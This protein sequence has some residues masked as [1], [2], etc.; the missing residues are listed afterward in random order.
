MSK[1]TVTAVAASLALAAATSILA[2]A[3]A[4][5]R[6]TAPGDRAD[7]VPVAPCALPVVKLKKKRQVAVPVVGRC[8]VPADAVAVA[9]DLQ[10]K[11]SR[12]GAL[13][14]W[15]TGSSLPGTP[16]LAWQTARKPVASQ[17][18]VAL[19]GGQMSLAGTKGKTK[20]TAEVVG[21]Y[22]RVSTSHT[23]TIN[24][25]SMILFGSTASYGTTNGCITN[26]DT[27]AV[28]G[29]VPLTLPVGSR[30]TSITT[31]VY[32]GGS[33]DTYA[34]A[35][36]RYL[37]QTNFLTVDSTTPL[38]SGG[39]GSVVVTTSTVN[40]SQVVDDQHS[41]AISLTNLKSFNNGLCGVRVTYEDPS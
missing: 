12:P 25:W 19:G 22:R 31:S 23:L 28:T 20:V 34:L 32:D 11:G 18:N 41:F 10:A 38:G 36:V 4:L 1:S 26:S 8:G 33:A 14:A 6:P 21:Y 5:A 35:L 7:Y 24:P 37:P 39:A 2:T 27:S 30:I 29:Y 15:A 40:V 16:I 17:A 3:P 9:V 13:R